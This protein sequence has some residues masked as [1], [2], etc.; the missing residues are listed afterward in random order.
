MS[1]N[2]ELYRAK[3]FFKNTISYRRQDF[4]C[5]K[6]IEDSFNGQHIENLQFDFEQTLVV[7]FKIFKNLLLSGEFYTEP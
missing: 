4:C 7:W 6:G 3:I 5:T 1:F 2:F